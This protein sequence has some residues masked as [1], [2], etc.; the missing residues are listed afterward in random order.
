MRRLSFAL[1]ALALAAASCSSSNSDTTDA[2]ATGTTVDIAAVLG[3]PNPATGSP[4]TLGFINEG[5]SEAIGSQAELVARGAQIAVDYANDYL[6]GLG[7]HKIE[8]FVCGNQSTPAGGTDC[9]NQMVEKKVVAVTHPYTGQGAAQVP[10][11]TS[12][13]IPYVTLSGASSDELTT[14]GV[15]AL[16]GGYPVTL[17]AFAAHAKEQGTKQFNLIVTDVPAATQGATAI[18]GIV[19]KNAGVDYEVTPVTPGTPDITPQLQAAIDGGADALGFTGDVT[20]CTTF[21][22]AYQ[23]LGLSVPKYVLS[24]CNEKSLIDSL[25]SVLAGSFEAVTSGVSGN[26][27]AQYAAMTA[28]YNEGDAI[29]PDPNLSA[30]IAAGLSTVIDLLNGTKNIGTDVTAATVL[31]AIK[32]STNVP[33]FLSGGLTFTCDGK[34]V[35]IL[36]NV[37]SAEIQLGTVDA[38]GQVSDLQKIDTTPLF[39]M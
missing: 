12:A 29:D 26:E 14:A 39:K 8:L 17:A 1:V 15:F 23:T 19:F 25:G 13:G 34:A 33:L 9:A 36:P 10:V 22:Q 37:C 27:P 35:P 16:T 24:T 38:T 32:A 5:G 11:V 31:A 6:G 28:K 7:G 3:T 2:N 18:G 21:L 30:G 20:F 4:V